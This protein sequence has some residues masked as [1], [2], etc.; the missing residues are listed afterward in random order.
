[1]PPGL[2]FGPCSAPPPRFK[3]TKTATR[4]AWYWSQKE[5]KRKVWSKS[6]SERKRKAEVPSRKKK[7]EDLSR[8]KKRED[9]LKTP[10]QRREE[11]KQRKGETSKPLEAK[12]DT[13][14]HHGVEQ[15]DATILKVLGR[16]YKSCK[17][18][19]PKIKKSDLQVE[20]LAAPKW[21]PGMR[22]ERPE[23]WCARAQL[24]KR[25]S[26]AK[27]LVKTE[28]AV[29]GQIVIC[30]EQKTS[31]KSYSKEGETKTV[32]EKK[33]EAAHQVPPIV[34]VGADYE[35]D[36]GQCSSGDGAVEMSWPLPIQAQLEPMPPCME[37][38]QVRIERTI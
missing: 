22:E 4:K 16:S 13:K 28:A 33:A 14:S 32:E 17:R 37:F 15:V 29:S 26:R 27:K 35:A 20:E 38:Y 2:V 11:E 6:G 19:A 36:G 18:V 12:R 23:S 24:R 8:K 9:L 31:T 5:K 21:R 7:R 30:S 25:A 34:D 3:R 10:A 1:M